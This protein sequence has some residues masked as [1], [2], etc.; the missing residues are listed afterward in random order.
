MRRILNPQAR[1]QGTAAC[2]NSSAARWPVADACGECTSLGRVHGGARGRMRSVSHGQCGGW[3]RA[4][5]LEPR[6]GVLLFPVCVLKHRVDKQ[7]VVVGLRQECHTISP[8]T[9]PP[10]VL[11][12]SPPRIHAS[13]LARSFYAGSMGTRAD[14]RRE[15]C[16]QEGDL[17]E[18][19][20]AG[21]GEGR[22]GQEGGGGRRGGGRGLVDSRQGYEAR[23]HCCS[24]TDWRV[25]ITPRQ[26]KSHAHPPKASGSW[27][28]E[29]EEEEN[30]ISPWNLKELVML[31]HFAS[32]SRTNCFTGASSVRS[33][34]RCMLHLTIPW[35]WTEG[36]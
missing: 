15:A 31:P 34:P 29:E 1:L 27:R 25:S 20:D 2:G 14:G 26:H 4:P 6:E 10:V 9:P 24:C 17:T 19:G 35:E 12:V 22:K 11:S 32:R 16:V 13:L 28:E 23:S 3:E 7:L 36:P 30:K 33:R 18:Q 5:R 8:P 21:G